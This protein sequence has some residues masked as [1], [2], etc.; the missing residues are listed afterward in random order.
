M[1]TGIVEAWDDNEGWG[2]IRSGETPGGCWFNFTDLWRS[3]FRRICGER[4]IK[5]GY[6]GAELDEV[7]DFDWEAGEQDGYLYRAVDVRPRR[8]MPDWNFQ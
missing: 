3:D 7:V 5:T 8:P 1:A 4:P 6:K 2:V